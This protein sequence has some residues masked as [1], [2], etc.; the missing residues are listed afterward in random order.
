M[1]YLL[2][3]DYTTGVRKWFEGDGKGGFSLVTEQMFP[4]GNVDMVQTL[5]ED[6][7]DKRWNELIKSDSEVQLTHYAHIPGP[8]L[9]RWAAQGIDLGNGLELMRMLNS[10]EYMRLRSVDKIHKGLDSDGYKD[11]TESVREK[12]ILTKENT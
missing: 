7:G 6:S 5:K 2:S 4:I 9:A 10:P 1:K 11:A 3:E 12:G 8:V